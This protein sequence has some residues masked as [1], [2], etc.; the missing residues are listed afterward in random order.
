MAKK[1]SFSE[2]L[3]EM[4]NRKALPVLDKFLSGKMSDGDMVV[5]AAMFTVSKAVTVRHQ[6]R[7]GEAVKRGQ[8]IRL[9]SL[10]FDTAEER[11]AYIQATHPDVRLPAPK[12]RSK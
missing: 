1:Q 11:R 9:A 4:A 7:V 12:A 5:N 3:Q 6:D 8:N 2:K 10:L